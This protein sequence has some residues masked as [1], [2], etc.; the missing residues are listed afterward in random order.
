MRRKVFMAGVSIAVLV[1]IIVGLFTVGGP[2]QAR[3]DMFDQ[4]RY[5]DLGEIA[6]ALSCPNWRVRKPE[7][8][9]EL[10][11]E[12]LRSY[13]GGV[14]IAADVLL[15]NE[16]GAPY[17]YDRKNGSEFSVCADFYD[18]EKTMRLGY[19]RYPDG[20]QTSF[21]PETGCVTGRV[22]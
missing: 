22:N 3:R 5:E 17:V 12:S 20:V 8:P 18:A 13:C 21:N 16:T 10:T 15:D 14:Q 19:R 2:D 4:R 9:D 6:Y 11:L 1:A 7:L